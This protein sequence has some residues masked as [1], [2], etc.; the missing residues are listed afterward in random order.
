MKQWNSK[1]KIHIAY[2]SLN[3]NDFKFASHLIVV[4]GH[5]IWKVSIGSLLS[6]Y[7]Q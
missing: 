1:P 5:A 3:K 7:L 6:A 2:T 4:A